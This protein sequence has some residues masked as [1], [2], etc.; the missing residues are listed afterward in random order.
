MC[1]FRHDSHLLRAL[2]PPARCK[3]DQHPQIT[4][5]IGNESGTSWQLASQDSNAKSLLLDSH[6]AMHSSRVRVRVRVDRRAVLQRR[7]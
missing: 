4:M 5:P 7:R 6:L 1:R 2:G 3:V